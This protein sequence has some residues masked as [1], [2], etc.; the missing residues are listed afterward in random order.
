[1]D[2]S[3]RT[4]RLGLLLVVLGMAALSGCAFGTRHVELSYPPE[5]GEGGG[6]VAAARADTGNVPRCCE[7]ILAVSD[8]RTDIRRIGNVRNGF[9]MDTADVVT[10]SD[11]TAWVAGAFRQELAEAGYTVV[12]AESNAASAGAVR[13]EA[14]ITTVYCDVIFSYKG[15]VWM[16]VYLSGQDSAPI[17]NSYHGSGS[18]GLNWAA[19]SDSY[20]ESLARAL[21]DAVMQVMADLAQYQSP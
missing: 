8:R 20:A 18:A 1:M 2:A 10:G 13:L 5:G 17:A 9:G 21:R 14:E 4:G 7:V 16:N 19:T 11:V 3:W 12:P 6:L 15:D